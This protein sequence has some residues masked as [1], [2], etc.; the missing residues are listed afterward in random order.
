LENA[1][2]TFLAMIAIRTSNPATT[3]ILLYHDFEYDTWQELIA[4]S[5]KG[6]GMIATDGPQPE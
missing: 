1:D 4:K 5:H 3:A 2:V 6:F